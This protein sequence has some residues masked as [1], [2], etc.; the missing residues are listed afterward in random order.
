MERFVLWIFLEKNDSRIH[1]SYKDTVIHH[2]DYEY[3]CVRS[4]GHVMGQGCL[5]ANAPDACRSMWLRREHR[6]RSRSGLPER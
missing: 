5:N 4:T 1:E 6:A 3:D 2:C